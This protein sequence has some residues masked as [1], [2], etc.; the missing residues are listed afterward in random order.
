VPVVAVNVN[1]PVP[2]AHNGPLAER[3]PCGKGFTVTLK[4]VPVLLEQLFPFFTVIVP[5]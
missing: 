4:L 3:L 5:E 2:V 1:V